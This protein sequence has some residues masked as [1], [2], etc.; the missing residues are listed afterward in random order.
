MSNSFLEPIARITQNHVWMGIV[1]LGVLLILAVVRWIY[2]AYLQRIGRAYISMY[3]VSRFTIEKSIRSQRVTLLMI[4]IHLCTVSLFVVF[5][6]QYVENVQSTKTD[7][8]LLYIWVWTVYGALMMLRL[9]IIGGLGRQLHL[10]EAARQLNQ[11]FLISVQFTG[12]VLLTL[13]IILIFV[14]PVMQKWIIHIINGCIIAGMLYH[15]FREWKVLRQY[16]F[17]LLH[18]FLYLC[19]FEIFPVWWIVKTILKG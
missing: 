5:H 19:A 18:R 8:V 10:F 14:L 7:P 12:M 9:G 3:E 17:S 2:P 1:L 4:L 11:L 13:M 16:H 6:Y 15:T